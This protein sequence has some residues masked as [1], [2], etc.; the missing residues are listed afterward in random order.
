MT[1]EKVI[2]TSFKHTSSMGYAVGSQRDY[3]VESC[4]KSRISC[5]VM[6][7]KYDKTTFQNI[8]QCTPTS[9]MCLWAKLI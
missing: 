3:F 4:H 2:S 1:E 9:T 6:T 5:I 7:L 8:S